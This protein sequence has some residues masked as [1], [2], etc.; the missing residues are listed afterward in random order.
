[1]M[2]LS[3]RESLRLDV[4]GGNARSISEENNFNPSANGLIFASPSAPAL[5]RHRRPGAQSHSHAVRQPWDPS[6]PSGVDWTSSE[7][8]EELFRFGYSLGKV[9]NLSQE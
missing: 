8:H 4:V 6:C 3:R 7:A 9:N 5:L 1:M 2:D